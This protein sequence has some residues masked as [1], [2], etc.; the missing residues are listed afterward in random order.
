MKYLLSSIFLLILNC[1]S[2]KKTVPAKEEIKEAT[3]NVETKKTKKITVT[4]TNN[5]ELIVV[6]KNSKSSNDVKSLVK[7]SG[8]TWS[9]TA[10]DTKTTAIGIITVPNDQQ[11]IWIKRLQETGEFRFIAKNSTKTL[12][13][14][15]EKEKNTLISLRK[16]ACFGD[17]PEFDFSIDK[18]GNALYNG[19]KSV[20]VKGIHKFKL[21]EKEF[22]TLKEK[23]SKKSF[24]S[25]NDVYDNPRVMDLASTFITYENKQIKIRLWND[26]PDEL[27]DIHEYIEGLLLEKKFYE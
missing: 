27:I 15:I 14:L 12:N 1:S 4:E 7:N 19:I 8:L 5:N 17:C 18:D 23:L 22:K 25:F 21:T 24:E 20:T 10:Y 2:P 11:D 3:E 16:T 26:I 9:K 13:N 6:L